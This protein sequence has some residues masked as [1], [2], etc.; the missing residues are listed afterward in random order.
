MTRITAFALFVIS[1]AMSHEAY[2]QWGNFG[3]DWSDHIERSVMNDSIRRSPNSPPGRSSSPA[4]TKVPKRTP[5]IPAKMA[6]SAPPAQRA[7][8][9]R[10][11]TTLLSGY[12][13]LSAKLHVP[14]HELAGAFAMLVVG[15]YAA[16][17][18]T[19]V[20]PGA[21]AATTKQLRA[22]LGAPLAKLTTETKQDLYEQ[23]AIVSTMLVG[24]ID[25]G[26]S[27]PATREQLRELGKQYLAGFVDPDRL[28]ITDKG[29]SFAPK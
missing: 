25:R 18:G 12:D 10:T 22:A 4:S 19:E 11:Y 2:A 9:E 14:D 21:L 24:G 17:H 26:K 7:A 13:A 8:M 15:S 16:Y 6:A 29:M 23:L 28:Q 3:I 27:D 5:R 20:S 1:L